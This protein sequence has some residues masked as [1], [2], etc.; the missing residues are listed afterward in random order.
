[1]NV[2]VPDD[3]SAHVQSALSSSIVSKAFVDK[4]VNEEGEATIMDTQDDVNLTTQSDP[5]DE[6]TPAAEIDQNET[7]KVNDSVHETSTTEHE[8]SE[9]KRVGGDVDNEMVVDGNEVA[10]SLCDDGGDK[11]INSLS[12][13]AGDKVMNSQ[14]EDG[15]GK[16]INSQNEDGG[17][18]LIN[19]QNEDGGDKV[20]NSQNED[21][22]SDKVMNS[23]NEDGGDKVMNAQKDSDSDKVINSQNDDG[24]DKV[25]NSQKDGDENEVTDSLNEACGD[26]AVNPQNDLSLTEMSKVKDVVT[27]ANQKPEHVLSSAENEVLKQDTRT[28][29]IA[30]NDIPCESAPSGL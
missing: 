14:N 7:R 4:P 2:D 1:M 23:Q 6:K 16:V 9:L 19:S 26:E 27:N 15:G 17:D 10:N 13:D 8:M 12:D 5:N 3:K 28:T 30:A 25:T 29:E 18:K 20:I 22:K 24:E 21:G 11:V